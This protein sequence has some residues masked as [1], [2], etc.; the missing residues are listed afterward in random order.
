MKYVVK[1]PVIHEGVIIEV[2]GEVELSKDQAE[3]LIEKGCIEDKKKKGTS[4]KDDKEE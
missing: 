4:E 3:H 1:S 2:G